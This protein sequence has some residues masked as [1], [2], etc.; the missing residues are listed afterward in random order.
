MLQYG[1]KISADRAKEIEK[2]MMNCG[3]KMTQEEVNE[4]LSYAPTNEKGEVDYKEF[5]KI[6]AEKISHMKMHIYER[7]IL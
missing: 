2:V 7:T 1:Q 5:A 6:L 4:F 3:D